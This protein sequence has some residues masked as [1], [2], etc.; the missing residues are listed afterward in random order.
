MVDV[1]LGG[2]LGFFVP[3]TT[4]GS[5]RPDGTDALE[6]ARKSGY[7]VFTD[8]AGF[9][10]LN[11]GNAKAASKPYLGLFHNSHMNYEIDRDPAKEPSLLEMAKTAI[12]SLKKATRYS[13]KGYFIVS[14]STST[15]VQRSQLTYRVDGRGFGM[16]IP[17]ST[18]R[19]P[20]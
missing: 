18:T 15:L 2:G 11:G 10:A 1:L 12:T 20:S 16:M 8:R 5:T 17:A 14:H 3:N 19:V 9:D 13:D 7:N 6:L 4:T